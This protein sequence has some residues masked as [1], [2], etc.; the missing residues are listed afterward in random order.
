MPK[1]IKEIIRMNAAA[2]KKGPG[3]YHLSFA[4]KYRGGVKIVRWTRV[5]KAGGEFGGGY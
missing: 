4:K 1:E 3:T 5:V 2:I